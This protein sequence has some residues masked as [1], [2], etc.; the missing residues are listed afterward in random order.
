MKQT[1]HFSAALALLLIMGCSKKPDTPS[2]PLQPLIEVFSVNDV[3]YDGVAYDSVA[4]VTWRLNGDLR[5]ATLNGAPIRTAGTIKTPMLYHDTSFILTATGPAGMVT[6]TKTCHATITPMVL[7]L[8]GWWQM[9]HSEVEEVA[10]GTIRP[11]LVSS[12]TTG[13]RQYLGRA[14]RVE[15]DY[16]AGCAPPHQ[17]AN[18]IGTPTPAGCS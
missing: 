5:S 4:T 3:T 9:T 8:E 13:M 14:R 10:T 18:C 6:Q 11:T 16:P 15:F 1:F 2:T 12:C 7:Q 17:Q